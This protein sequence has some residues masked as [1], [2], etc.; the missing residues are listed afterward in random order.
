MRGRNMG[1][2]NICVCCG[3][4][5]PEGRQV[6]KQCEVVERRKSKK[7]PKWT[8][9]R[10]ARWKKKHLEEMKENERN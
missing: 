3:R 9:R 10:A 2:E 1:N 6:C 7:T 4:P 8:K 5:I